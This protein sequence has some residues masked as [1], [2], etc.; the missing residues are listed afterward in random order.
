MAIWQVKISCLVLH[1]GSYNS[2][3]RL[4]LCKNATIDNLNS[5]ILEDR[6]PTGTMNPLN[7]NP[8]LWERWNSTIPSRKM[9][10]NTY[11]SFKVFFACHLFHDDYRYRHLISPC[12]P[13]WFYI[14]SL[15]LSKWGR[16][17]SLTSIP[18][19]S[20]ST[21]QCSMENRHLKKAEGGP[22]P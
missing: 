10:K 20:R 5:K 13:A 18:A 4:E 3:Q 1:L 11:L 2:S 8:F 6:L 7:C 19:Y 16:F 17:L 22:L 9:I 14:Y 15:T 12:L 21:A